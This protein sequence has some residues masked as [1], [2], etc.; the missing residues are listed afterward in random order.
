MAG[1]RSQN[2][3][4]EAGVQPIRKEQSTMG[5]LYS[6]NSMCVAADNKH[7]KTHWQLSFMHLLTS[8]IFYTSTKVV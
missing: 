2:T 7:V 4:G 8:N 1:E 3:D 6:Y 5:M